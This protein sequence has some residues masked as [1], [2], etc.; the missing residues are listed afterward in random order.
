MPKNKLLRERRE[1][2]SMLHFFAKRFRYI[3]EVPR[4]ERGFTLIELLVVMIILGILAAIAIPAFLAQRAKAQDAMAKS[5]TRNAG[6]AE[7]LYYTETD[8][9]TDDLTLLEAQGFRQSGPLQATPTQAAFTQAPDNYCV[10]T[11]SLS[12][13]HT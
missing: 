7:V 1:R 13:A 10:R 6:T 8:V 5:D 2:E 3:Q 4:E 9:Y 12:G 11:D